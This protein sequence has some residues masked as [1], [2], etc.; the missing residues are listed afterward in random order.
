VN[1][2]KPAWRRFLSSLED[3][4]HDMRQEPPHINYRQRRITAAD[5]QLLRRCIAEQTSREPRDVPHDWLTAF[6]AAY[7]GG[8][9]GFAPP[10]I[11]SVPPKDTMIQTQSSRATAEITTGPRYARICQELDAA[12]P[13]HNPHDLRPP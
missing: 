5:P 4:V 3:A 2:P 11:G 1:T 7:T 8:D 6:W 10:V 13:A 12:I 9:I